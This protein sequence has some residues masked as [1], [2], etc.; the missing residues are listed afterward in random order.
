[1]RLAWLSRAASKL[2]RMACC[3]PQGAKRQFGGVVGGAAG[4][5]SNR[6]PLIGQPDVLEGGQTVRLR[7]ILEAARLP[8]INVASRLLE[9]FG[10]P[11]NKPN[12]LVA[13]S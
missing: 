10:M 8:R 6:G 7:A 9:S 3:L 11:G 12:E 2:C 13:R 1:M 4:H 5:Y